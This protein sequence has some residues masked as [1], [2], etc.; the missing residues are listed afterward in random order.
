MTAITLRPPEVVMRLNRLGA[1]HP[2]RLSFLR[3]LIRRATREKWRVR[4]HLFDLDDNGFGRAVYAVEMPARTYSLVAFSTP[5]DDE[6]RS[7]RVIA[8]AWDTSYV[9]YDGLPD[10]AEIARLEANAPLQEAGR[11][12]GSELVLARANKSVRLFEEV[13]SALAEGRQPDEDQLLGV[14]YLLRTTAV[15][16]NG[17]FGIADRDE[18]ALRPELAGSFQA[19]MLT[20]WLIRSFTFD[21]VDHIARRR[22]PAGATKLAPDLRRA[23]GVG[24]ATGLGMA[25]FLVRHPLL[26]HSWFLARE[27]ALARVRAEPSTGAA[28][29]DAFLK[30]LGDLRRRVAR[31]HSDDSRQAAATRLLAA[32]LD[33]LAESLDRLL[34]EPKP[35]DAVYRFAEE[36]FSLEGQEA[37]VSLILEPHGALVDDLG[38]TMKADETPGHAIDGSIT[39]GSLSQAL[40]S[41]YSWA[42]DIDFADPAANARFWYVSAEKLEPR[43]GERFEEDGAELE[44]PLATARDALGLAAA[45][46]HEPAS[47]GV[48][49]FLLRRPEWRHAVRRAQI[50]GK[51]PYA[52]IHDNLIGAELRPVDILRAKLAFFGARSFDPRSDRWLRIALFSG[53]PLIEDIA[54]AGAAA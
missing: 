39:C 18:I 23:M 1:A 15:Y 13:A 29:R 3:Q 47:S 21:L 4:K 41:C 28:E 50:V 52:E 5:L 51:Y 22:N 14:G 12:T 30:S 32:D 10:E 36:R 38:D 25:P 17:K 48:A 33:T 35:W 6:N 53:E 40:L 7:D 34:A 20:V 16:G 43:L 24:N 45:L 19:E 8:Q 46:A 54:A 2:T 27:T 49:D 31:W 11:Y 37:C 26:T 42:A 44:Q 9:L